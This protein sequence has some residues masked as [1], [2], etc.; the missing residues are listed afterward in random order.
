[1][2][3]KILLAINSF[4]ASIITL[5]G[6]SSCHKLGMGRVECIYGG[7]D[8]MNKVPINKTINEQDS[9]IKQIDPIP[10]EVDKQ[11]TIEDKSDVPN[12]VMYGTRFKEYS[13]EKKEI[14]EE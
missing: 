2:K 6:F 8:M 13:E 1:M 7:P 14:V 3:R 9:A 11:D 12:M 10:A 5:L 4:L